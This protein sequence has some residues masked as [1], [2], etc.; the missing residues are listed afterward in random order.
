M[1]TKLDIEKIKK[2]KRGSRAM[3]RILNLINKGLRSDGYYLYKED[4]DSDYRLLL[5]IEMDFLQ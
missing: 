4:L 2:L 3:L 1:K 5:E